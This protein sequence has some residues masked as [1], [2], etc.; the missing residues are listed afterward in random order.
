MAHIARIIW[1][2]V[3]LIAAANHARDIVAGGWLPYGFAPLPLNWFWTLLLPL[4]L[5]AALLVTTR[6][7]A[8]VI[9]G[10]AII[11]AD[12]AA[13]SWFA[14]KTQ[15]IALYFALQWQCMFLGFVLG[16]VGP[17]WADFEKV[18]LQ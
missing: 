7:R 2:I 16:T 18:K 4:D 12:V 6:R 17:L 9:L 13:N 1:V 8:G 10:F 15:W 14:H 3:F 5:L 11:L